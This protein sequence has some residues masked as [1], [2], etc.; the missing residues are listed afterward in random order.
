MKNVWLQSLRDSKIDPKKYILHTAIPSVVVSS[1]VF[2]LIY[3]MMIRGGELDLVIAGLFALLEIVIISAF[4]LLPLINRQNRRRNIEQEMHLFITRVGVLSTSD[5]SRKGI[6]NI[7]QEMKEYGEL[8]IE[9]NKIFVLLDTWGLSIGDACRRVAKSTP[10]VMFGDF[11]E[12]LAYAVESGEEPKDFFAAEQEIILEQYKILYAQAADSIAMAGEIFIAISM[13]MT[14]L[15][16]IVALI[17]FILGVNTNTWFYLS[18]LLFIAVEC[19]MLYV[20]VAYVPRERVWQETDIKTKISRNL[21]YYFIAS[22]G[23][24]FLLGI[25]VFVFGDQTNIL[26]P[27][28]AHDLFHHRSFP[29]SM[30]ITLT[31]LIVS[32]YYTRKKEQEIIRTDNNFAAF[33]RSLGS[34]SETSSIAPVQALKRLKWHDFGP[35]TRHIEALYDRVNLRIDPVRSWKYFGAETGSDLITKF[36]GMFV[37]G[38]EAG[39][40]PGKA[41]QI[42][43]F[44]FTKLIGL[45]KKRYSIAASLSGLFI[46]IA[47]VI[48][49]VMFMAGGLVEI[50]RDLIT[51][52][53][54]DKS[55]IDVQILQV[56]DYN[57]TLFVNLMF[58]LIIIHA[59]ITA[60]IHIIVAAGH[61]YGAFFNFVIMV[62]IG[63]IM[64]EL[65]PW[66]IIKLLAPS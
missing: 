28:D 20:F 57:V 23:A 15:I 5:I 10:S 63:A 18:A 36:S 19:L 45:R 48:S 62:W 52:S 47:I 55:Y 53:G 37:R 61:K 30:A 29:I 32:G 46:G 65:A 59:A 31:P 38:L 27:Y 33:I 2:I 11:L 43:S 60:L 22:V 34:T 24:C 4:I 35:L 13:V 17:P 9:I 41:A 16:L 6:F 26:K 42:I 54:A 25:I 50:L 1:F 44:N 49:L 21:N 66:V 56:S 64:S 51:E 7:A 58:V 40:K 3:Y 12:R 14:F 8:A 39:G